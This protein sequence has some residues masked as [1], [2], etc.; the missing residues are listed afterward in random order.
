MSTETQDDAAVRIARFIVDDLEYGGPVT[1]FLGAEPVRLPEAI[2]S[3]ALLELATFIEDEFGVQIQDE[4][5]V[6]EN[7][8]T[9]ADVVRLLRDK[10]ALTQPE[11]TG[12]QPTGDQD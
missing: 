4:D 10:G 7:F 11:P 5:I 6:P 1:D 8:A 3:A 2:D 12:D 9:V